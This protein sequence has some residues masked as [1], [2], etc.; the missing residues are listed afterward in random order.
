MTK[1]KKEKQPKKTKKPTKDDVIDT[2]TAQDTPEEQPNDNKSESLIVLNEKVPKKARWYVV[3]TY[4]GHEKR[5]ADL[6]KALILGRDFSNK[7]FNIL[8]PTQ[9]KIIV[10]EGKKRK[11]NERLYPG[12]IIVNMVMDD[13]AW[14]LVRSTKGVTGFVSAGD[15]PTPLP[16]K[17]VDSIMRHL[18]MEAPK[19]E[20]KYKVGDS[21]KI[22]EGPFQDFLGKV[23]EVNED[24]GKARVLVSVFGRETPVELDFVQITSI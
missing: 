20:T 8:I 4:S 24:Q 11:I 12:Y 9:K 21:V 19:F 2:D 22:N 17:E 15:K 7:I 1:N 23:D 18:T 6:I 16:Q 10:S 3:H 14:Y 5:V 13:D